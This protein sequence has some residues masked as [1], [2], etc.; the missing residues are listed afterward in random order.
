MSDPTTAAS[1]LMTGT[2]NGLVCSSSSSPR[3]MESVTVSS[4]L[5]SNA[6]GSGSVLAFS[7]MAQKYRPGL[8]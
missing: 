6:K 2:V 5:V 1:C 8:A 4:H 3:S 7:T